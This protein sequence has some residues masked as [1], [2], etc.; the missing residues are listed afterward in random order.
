MKTRMEMLWDQLKPVARGY[1]EAQI[2]GPIGN[3]QDQQQKVRDALVTMNARL[4]II[5]TAIAAI[6]QRLGLP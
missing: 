5:E 4:A 1:V 2:D 3:V 6:K